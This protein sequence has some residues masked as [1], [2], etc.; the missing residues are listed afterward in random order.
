L[1]D[2]LERRRAGCRTGPR[3]P[4]DQ[5]SYTDHQIC[6]DAHRKFKLHFLKR[7]LLRESHNIKTHLQSEM[8]TRCE[9]HTAAM[10]FS[11]SLDGSAKLFLDDRV[12]GI[13]K[14][15]L[16]WCALG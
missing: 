4:C 7:S 15:R 3:A 11:M 1:I 5:D 8:L 13:Y 12:I 9:D 10:V 16:R 14:T 6:V 2:W